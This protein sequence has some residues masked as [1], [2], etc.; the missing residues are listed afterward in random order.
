MKPSSLY[1]PR[2]NRR[3]PNRPLDPNRRRPPQLWSPWRMSMSRRA[4]RWRSSVESPANL[5][6]N[7]VFFLFLPKKKK[8]SFTSIWMWVWFLASGGKNL[9]PNILSECWKQWNHW[10][11]E[12]PRHWISIFSFL[13]DTE[14]SLSTWYSCYWYLHYL[15]LL[16][17]SNLPLFWAARNQ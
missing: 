11:W 12:D 17:L 7:F 1:R 8:K 5:V 14:L 16:H 4:L 15:R 9:R 2:N 3:P 10:T 6:S 13:T